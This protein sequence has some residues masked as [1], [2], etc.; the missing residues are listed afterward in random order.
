MKKPDHPIDSYFREALKEHRITPSQAAKEAFLKEAPLPGKHV[1]NRRKGFFFLLLSLLTVTCAGILWVVLSPAEHNTMPAGNSISATP[2]TA[3]D[4]KIVSANHPEPSSSKKTEGKTEKSTPR[5]SKTGQMFSFKAPVSEQG[6]AIL[7]MAAEP[8]L[9]SGDDASTASEKEVAETGSNAISLPD[10]SITAPALQSQNADTAIFQKKPDSILPLLSEKKKSDPESTIRNRK[11]QLSASVYYTPEWLFN[12]LEGDKFVNNVGIE[13]RF[14][15]GAYSVRTGVGLSIT[16]GSNEIA[17]AYND[18]LGSYQGLDSI[19]F[20]W[21]EEQGY[22]LSNYYMS[23]KDVWDS[24]MK[25]DHLKNEKRYTYLQIPLILGYDFIH[26]ENFSLGLRVGPTLSVL[27]QSKQMNENY[28]PGKNKI[29]R[30]NNVTPDR[31]QTNWQ[32]SGGINARLRL[33]KR[34]GVEVEP[35][36]RYYF[37]SVYEPSDI[38]KKPWSVGIRAALTITF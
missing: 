3:S 26:K 27:L 34:L 11:W 36:V 37:N 15:F 16:R 31:I 25:L 38:T 1:N 19:S 18:Y 2:L 6:K 17:I 30:V 35:N 32:V 20:R 5:E 9:P 12:T 4:T 7:T 23:N 29:I 24:L 8:E 13:G 33:Y 10:Q 21:S 14:H 28:D 22:L